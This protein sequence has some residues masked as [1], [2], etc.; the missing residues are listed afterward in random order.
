M[1]SCFF[2][3]VAIIEMS[4]E[5]MGLERYSFKL[6]FEN[7]ENLFETFCTEQLSFV[8]SKRYGVARS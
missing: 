2:E 1:Q 4:L 8:I 6:R 7:S 5:I 3:R